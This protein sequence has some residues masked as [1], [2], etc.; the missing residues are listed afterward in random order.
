MD[1]IP[2]IPINDEENFHVKT[3]I[4]IAGGIGGSKEHNNFATEAENNFL[5]SDISPGGLLNI[6]V[7]K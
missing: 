2:P 3:P 6:S 5:R 7:K 1:N 4:N